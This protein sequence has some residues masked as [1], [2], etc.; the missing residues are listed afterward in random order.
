MLLH[1]MDIKGATKIELFKSFSPYIVLKQ[2]NDY[3]IIVIKTCSTL[4]SAL[5]VVKNLAFQATPS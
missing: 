4:T 2:Q 5:G 3:V 1:T